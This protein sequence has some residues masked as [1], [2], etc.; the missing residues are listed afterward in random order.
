MSSIQFGGSDLF[1]HMLAVGP[2]RCGKTATLLKPIIY[3][4]LL[5]KKKGVP[6][7]LSVV[8]PKGDVAA[9]V[10]EMAGE[11][12]MPCVHV[13]PTSPT[14]ARFPVMKG[15]E[16]DVAEATVTVLKSM[17]GKQEAFF[18]T[19]QELAGRNITKLLKRLYLDDVNLGDVLRTMRDQR[20]L[21]DKVAEL[22]F[23]E[24]ESDLVQFFQSELLGAQKEKYQQFVIGLRAQ[25]ENLVSNRHLEPILMGQSDFDMDAHFANGGI[26][27][28]NTAMGKLRKA[29]DAFGQFGIMHLQSGTFRRPGT[30]L[31]RIPHFILADEYSRYINPDVE[32]FLSIAAEYRT[33]GFFATQSLGQLEVEAGKVSAKA[34]KQ[35][36]LTSCRNKIAFGGLAYQDALEFSREFG[37]KQ[38]ISRQSTFKQQLLVPNLLPETYRD[39]ETEEDRIF[40]TQMMDGLP[41]FHYVAKLL[42]DGT[43]LPPKIGKGRFVPHDWKER[44]EWEVR[45]K[46]WSFKFHF[47]RKRDH[48]VSD[49]VTE[50]KS[51][52]QE[53]EK[54]ISSSRLTF[55]QTEQPI[56]HSDVDANLEPPIQETSHIHDHSQ[57]KEEESFEMYLFTWILDELKL[58]YSDNDIWVEVI[59]HPEAQAVFQMLFQLHGS[60]NPTLNKLH[61]EFQSRK[62][63]AIAVQHEIEDDPFE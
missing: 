40:Y 2:T 8:E 63:Q 13:D 20:V 36:I 24:G 26:L 44:R 48:P 15:D 59:Q 42:Q 62:E 5:M 30:E 18:A 1:T 32:L 23:K 37:K 7:G 39:T 10:A 3:Q 49:Q 31:T 25:L 22:R 6:L 56:E 4:L 28:I 29:G 51:E 52:F 34:M 33:A 17:F 9:M 61:H 54:P 19:V 27:A 35:A 41:K 53:E 16:D 11:M 45:K 21:E 46:Q 14:S 12:D 50:H 58:Q 38:I 47:K 57:V 43:P 60:E 55:I